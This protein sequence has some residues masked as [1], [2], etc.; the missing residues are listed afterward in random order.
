MMPHSSMDEENY[1]WLLK[2][3]E[4]KQK[5]AWYKPFTVKAEL[6]VA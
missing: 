6:K 2:K 1:H 3:K 4:I 5:Q